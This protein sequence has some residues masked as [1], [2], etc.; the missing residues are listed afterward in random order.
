MFKKLSLSLLMLVPIYSYS[1]IFEI[2]KS[3]KNIDEVK[4]QIF[5]NDVQSPQKMEEVIFDTKNE[6]TIEVKFNPLY[7]SL[8]SNNVQNSIELYKSYQNTKIDGMNTPLCFAVLNKKISFLEQ[9]KINRNESEMVSCYNGVSPLS[10]AATFD[11]ITILNLLLKEKSE[12]IQ[13][14]K[15]TSSKNLSPLFSTIQFTS[16]TNPI[17][18]LIDNKYDVNVK[19]K[20]GLTPLHYAGIFSKEKHWNILV[21]N[22]ADMTAKDNYGNTP[23]YYMN[24]NFN[25]F[26]V[27]EIYNSLPNDEK[28]KFNEKLGKIGSSMDSLRK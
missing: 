26:K 14:D 6:S 8:V 7:E 18:L 25:I 15:K 19:D 2:D 20:N 16:S 13:K 24:K 22:G 28:Q 27:S 17:N 3:Q 21:K 12:K 5:S 11:D 4:E 1:Q 23:L 10:I 9:I